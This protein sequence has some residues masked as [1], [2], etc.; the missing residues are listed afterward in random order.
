MLRPFA[1]LVAIAAQTLLFT[2]VIPVN[3]ATVGFLYLIAIL[4]IATGWGLIE[5]VLASVAATL[6]YNYFFLPPVGTLHVADP[7]N[8]VA[9]VTFLA[10]SLIASQLSERAKRRAREAAVRELEMQRLYALS[11]AILLAETERPL[12]QHIA[13]ET[14]RIYGSP[15]VL[16]YDSDVR[17][18]YHAGTRTIPE[19]ERQLLD[20]AARGTR[21]RDDPSQTIVSA[22]GAGGQ[23]VGSIALQGASISDMAFQGLLNLISLGLEKARGLE[24]ATRAEAARQSEEFKSTLLDALA[25]EFKTPLTSIKAATT[26]ILASGAASPEDLREVVTII[27]QE[28][29]RLGA[30]VNEATHLARIEAGKLQLNKRPSRARSI[31]DAALASLAQAVEG[32]PVELSVPDDLP[33]IS[34][35]ADLMQTVFRHLIDNAVKYSPPLSSISITAW[36]AGSILMFSVRNE[37]EGIAETEQSRIFEKYYRGSAVRH[38]IP[39]TGMGLALA[40]E[41]VL[42]HGGEIRVESSPGQGAEFSVSVPLAERRIPV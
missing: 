3:P 4:L 42:A 8:W 9:L 20:A 40:S 12:A 29:S 19:L 26:G 41:I 34:V 21:L 13:L 15:L 35:D 28:A 39:G 17:Q 11:R 32:R 1:A 27:D 31:I 2:R 7:L 22:I 5:A 37:G 14:A 33:A 18:T 23:T 16:I 38:R 25:H 6:C 24:A 10:T 30:L 36:A